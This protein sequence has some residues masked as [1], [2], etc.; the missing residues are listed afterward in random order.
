MQDFETQAQRFAEAIELE[1]EEGRLTFPTALLRL[2]H[3]R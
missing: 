1:L 3:L 2:L